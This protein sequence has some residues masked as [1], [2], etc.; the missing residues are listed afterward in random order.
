MTAEQKTK[1][2]L[3]KTKDRKEGIRSSVEL[4]ENNPVR[5]KKVVLKPNFNTADP[6]PGSTH[7]ETLKE[8]ILYLKELGAKSIT[9]GERSGPPKT[10]DVMEQLGVYRLAEE[11]GVEVVNF[12][13]LPADEL[14]KVDPPGSHW[15]D[16]FTVPKML[17][18]AECTVASPCLKTHQ[19]GGIFTMALK[20]AVGITPKQGTDYMKELHS[21]PHMRKLIAELNWGYRPDL[22]VLD[23]LESFVEGG[24]MSGR[25]VN[26]DLFIAGTDRVAI[27]AVGLA[28]L[29]EVG[30]TPAVMETPIFEQEQIARAV[31][32]GLGAGSAQQIDLVTGDPTSAE[33]AKKLRNILDR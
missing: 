31:E 10:A 32:L 30:S 19:F 18:E 28:V 2:A 3:V 17:K 20:L 14:V 33:Y 9:I 16:G 26:T 23:G 7:Q 27:D 24:P 12:D 5:D 21:S 29:K 22:I 1:V 25:R 13:E 4:L 6:Y 15:Q 11:L 8:L